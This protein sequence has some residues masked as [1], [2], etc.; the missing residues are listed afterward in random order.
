[1]IKEDVLYLVD[2]FNNQMSLGVDPLLRRS[3]SNNRII[4][5]N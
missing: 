5:N 1:M 3:K 2:R 4:F